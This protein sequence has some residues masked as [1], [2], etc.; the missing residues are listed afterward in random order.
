M[1]S[2]PDYQLDP[3][4]SFHVSMESVREILISVDRHK[5]CG[6]DN[7][8]GRIISECAEELAVPV[9]KL[10]S[11]S[12]EQGVVPDLWK[13]ANVVPIHKKG[14]KSLPSNYRSISL[15][16]NDIEN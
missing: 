10:C 5:A 7:V 4:C 3:L 8:S 9:T 6:P 2:P 14:V 12:L 16:P 11:L 15:M 13:C 1:P